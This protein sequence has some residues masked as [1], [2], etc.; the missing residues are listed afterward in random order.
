[1]TVIA[2]DLF[3]GADS[4]VAGTSGSL[5][6]PASGVYTGIHFDYVGTPVVNDLFSITMTFVNGTIKYQGRFTTTTNLRLER[7]IAGLPSAGTTTIAN[8]ANTSSSFPLAGRGARHR[9]KFTAASPNPTINWA[10][11]TR[12][13]NSDFTSATSEFTSALVNG[14]TNVQ[15]GGGGTPTAISWGIT[16]T[17][18]KVY[19]TIAGRT[20]DGGGSGPLAVGIWAQPTLRNNTKFTVTSTLGQPN[21]AAY[22]EGSV[23]TLQ[24]IPALPT[25][26]RVGC[27]FSATAIHTPAQ[28]VKLYSRMNLAG[29][30]GY[31][32]SVQMN[33]A[34]MVVRLYKWAGG[35]STRTLMGFQFTAGVPIAGTTYELTV[36]TGGYAVV[37]RLDG[38]LMIYGYDASMPAVTG[39][40]G[41]SLV[42]GVV[43]TTSDISMSEFYIDDTPDLSG[44]TSIPV[45][46]DAFLVCEDEFTG[47]AAGTIESRVPDGGGSSCVA[48]GHWHNV[49]V[50]N[51]FDPLLPQHPVIY[52][53][54]TVRQDNPY[55]QDW[56]HGSI[57]GLDDLP[58][59]LGDDYTVE[60]DGKFPSLTGTETRWFSA[61]GHQI[62]ETY[63]PDNADPSGPFRAETGYELNLEPVGDDADNTRANFTIY[64]YEDAFYVALDEIDITGIDNVTLYTIRLCVINDGDGVLLVCYLNGVVK[65][66]VRDSPTFSGSPWQT[67]TPGFCIDDAMLDGLEQGAAVEAVRV[68]GPADPCTGDPCT[69][70]PDNPYPYGPPPDAAP[71]PVYIWV[72]KN[73]VWEPVLAPVAGYQVGD[74]HAFANLAP[75]QVTSFAMRKN[76][77]FRYPTADNIDGEPPPPETLFPPFYDPCELLPVQPPGDIVPL[78]PITTRFFGMGNTPISVLGQLWNGTQRP[79]GTWT[80]GDVTQCAAK[81]SK[82]IVAQ[83]SYDKFKTGGRWDI[84]KYI[85]FINNVL[86]PLLSSLS[87][88]AGC[89]GYSMLDD[90]SS[91]NIWGVTGGIPHSDIQ[92]LVNYLHSALPGVLI[93]IRGLPSQFSSNLGFDFYTAQYVSWRGTAT[94]FRIREQGIARSRGAYIVLS[95]NYVHG[96]N[97]SSG[98]QV[99]NGTMN[100]G[101]YC[102]SPAEVI[103]YG[104]QLFVNPDGLAGS[105]GYQFGEPL[106]IN[107]VG[108]LDALATI[109]NILMA[110]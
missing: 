28:Y 51:I 97:G 16:G 14:F 39:D 38:V 7:V 107:Q 73:L 77:A 3:T 64:W 63:D 99:F 94:E 52:G 5:S 102:M 65:L 70:G 27:R 84:S 10:V 95:L 41:C 50:W 21:P 103:S 69:G 12:G 87:N 110:L 24:S 81:N 18:W 82:I 42:K 83:G 4:G 40:P 54:G 96:G 57:E 108:V 61:L 75:R 46:N 71:L 43:A 20:P 105:L 33:P 91:A 68:Y 72:M 45:C 15:L 6:V 22:A 37:A 34:G 60:V 76:L 49:N 26:Y 29:D 90:F 32:C 47:A 78:G 86:V 31:E 100:T 66:I 89:F 35:F 101:K 11:I 13:E 88:T 92:Y 59:P 19:N 30:T 8:I 104:T 44:I 9:I 109:R 74:I 55:H 93:G 62:L 98:I 23:A 2:R 80:P 25:E 85:D 53:D 58:T 106:F 56:N 67:G 36:D 48:T 17:S 1:M 79:A